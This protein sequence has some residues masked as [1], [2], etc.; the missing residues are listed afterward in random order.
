M[1]ICYFLIF[2][3]MSLVNILTMSS[4][5]DGFYNPIFCEYPMKNDDYQSVN[6]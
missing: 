3:F 6:N 1:S 2:S 4:D 5:S